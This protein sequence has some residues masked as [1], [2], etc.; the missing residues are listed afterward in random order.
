[1]I[2]WSDSLAF[3][4]PSLARRSKIGSSR[5]MLN[6]TFLT[7]SFPIGYSHFLYLFSA[8]CMIYI[9]SSIT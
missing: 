8:I 5:Q 2:E 3:D 9:H 1:M 7:N 4:V 6:L